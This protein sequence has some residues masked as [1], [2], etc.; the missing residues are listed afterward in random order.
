M[1]HP[2][3]SAFRAT[4]HHDVEALE[5]RVLMAVQL[6][7][8]LWTPPAAGA[9][10]VFRSPG[11][12]SLTVK[13]RR[14]LYEHL[15]GTVKTRLAPFINKADSLVTATDLKN[16]DQA[17]L[18]YMSGRFTDH[19]ESHWLYDPSQVSSILAAAKKIPSLVGEVEGSTSAP[20]V[21]GDARAIKA[22][23]VTYAGVSRYVHRFTLGEH[24]KRVDPA[25]G[26][27]VDMVGVKHVSGAYVDW[28]YPKLYGN[29]TGISSADA[30][31]ALNRFPLIYT[32]AGQF[33]SVVA[34]A[35]SYRWTGE[36]AFASELIAQLRSWTYQNQPLRP[37]AGTFGSD[38]WADY[39]AAGKALWEPLATAIRVSPLIHVQNLMIGTSA[40]TGEVNTL[41]MLLMQRHGS[42]LAQWVQTRGGAGERLMNKGHKELTALMTLSRMFPEFTDSQGTSGWRA[43]V[44]AYL[45]ATDQN[46][47]SQKVTKFGGAGAYPSPDGFQKEQSP[48]YAYVVTGNLVEQFLLSKRNR[49]ATANAPFSQ[50]LDTLT[51]PT[52]TNPSAIPLATRVNALFK[53]ANPDGTMP[54]AGDSYR[55]SMYPLFLSS[56]L[57]TTGQ[58]PQRKPAMFD[59]LSLYN[60]GLRP[61]LLTNPTPALNRAGV[62]VAN[63]PN[64]FALPYSGYF[65]L[66]QYGSQLSDQRDA[67]QLTFKIGPMGLRS[68]T[69]DGH[70]QYDLLNFELSGRQRPLI[71]DPGL[72]TYRKIGDASGNVW[73]RTTVAHNSF[74]VDDY[75]HARMDGYFGYT[76]P[77][78]KPDKAGAT[79]NGLYVEG[80]H[81]GY[82]NLDAN[83]QGPRLARSI[84]YDKGDTFLVID[85]AK[86]KSTK[87]HTYKIAFNI[88]TRVRSPVVANEWGVNLVKPVSGSDANGV[89]TDTSNLA[90]AARNKGN[91][92]IQPVPVPGHGLT[93]A[94]AVRATQDPTTG[95]TTGPFVTASDESGDAQPAARYYMT[96]RTDAAHATANFVTLI[97]T[98]DRASLGATQEVD[99]SVRAKVVSQT[100]DSVAIDLYRGTAK[101]RLY[102]YSP[103]MAGG[104]AMAANADAKPLE[105]GSTTLALPR[106]TST[107]F[108]TGMESTRP[109]PLNASTGGPVVTSSAA[110][111]DAAA[112]LGVTTARTAGPSLPFAHRA[113]E[114]LA[115]LV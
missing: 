82:V 23:N 25:S 15:S 111:A 3:W 16:Y 85:W 64:A 20:G 77:R 96:Q 18:D 30:R 42:M 32:S 91:L 87:P 9:A 29:Y 36:A 46:N 39:E 104:T 92:L 45:P 108:P 8:D 19:P 73:V 90:G 28:I 71:S 17:L 6:D 112:A 80:W 70:S 57:V 102:F 12:Q 35:L 65:M 26:N 61:D 62:A 43:L 38:N 5:S 109:P 59:F 54:E 113:I 10:P 13:H 41:F 1:A 14:F 24:P 21:I 48:N 47:F 34:E 98:Y 99:T 115:E 2:E 76:T 97:H 55:L 52:T 40:W 27:R 100:D 86:Q 84:W 75:S 78:L 50:I 68:N 72:Y 11:F 114:G 22:A 89:Y 31:A 67:T 74:T 4:G 83:G 94:A 79:L 106:T 101:R 53:I 37:F 49:S 105:R 7:P 107:A 69:A 44:S 93:V 33:P 51:K 56:S 63:V 110:A 81:N 95:K 103:F 58:W 60:L 66:Q 88:P